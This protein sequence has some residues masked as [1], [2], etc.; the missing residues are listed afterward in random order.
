MRDDG[1]ECVNSSLHLFIE[2]CIVCMFLSSYIS[3]VIIMFVQ[4]SV[5]ITATTLVEQ[6]LQ[7]M[8]MSR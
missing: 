7:M 8:R 3:C 4:S 5:S 2:A 1:C 6:I